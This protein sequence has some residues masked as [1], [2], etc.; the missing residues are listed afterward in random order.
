MSIANGKYDNI[1]IK[2]KKIAFFLI[3]LLSIGMI[4]FYSSKTLAT[5]FND[6]LVDAADLGDVAYVEKLLKQGYK[7]DQKGDFGTTALMR[8]AFRGNTELIKLL[9]DSGAYINSADIGGETALHLASKNGHADAVEML[10]SYGANVD[11]PDKE[12]WT[13]L[14]RATLAKQEEITKI[15][16]NKGANINAINDNKESVIMHAAIVGTPNIL[17]MILS[18]PQ[19][20]KISKETSNNAITLA[21]KKGNIEAEKILA[22]FSA[23]QPNNEQAPITEDTNNTST[24]SSNYGN[25]SS[26]LNT[27]P[28]K[29]NN[30]NTNQKS[31]NTN[32]T[33]T[34]SSEE[35]S[36]KIDTIENKQPK[37]ENVDKLL[38]LN[39]QQKPPEAITP[40]IE[41]KKI[42]VNDTTLTE[43][44]SIFFVQL[45]TFNNETEA[46]KSWDKVLSENKEPL[47]K[48]EPVIVKANVSNNA[49]DIV[50]RLRGGILQ[51]KKEA[52]EL[53]KTL[54]AKST[55]CF[56]VEIT[57]AGNLSPS[58]IKT[59]TKNEQKKSKEFAKNN[60]ATPEESKKEAKIKPVENKQKSEAMSASS[61]SS[62]YPKL[63]N[64]ETPPINTAIDNIKP[65]S[66][67]TTETPINQNVGQPLPKETL[68]AEQIPNQK[69]L[70][71]HNDTQ[72]SR[73]NWDLS[74]ITP[75]PQPNI[76][77]DV[78]TTQSYNTAVS[79]RPIDVIPPLEAAKPAIAS[80]PTTTQS[81][82][83]P[84]NNNKEDD[85]PFVNQQI[86]PPS[87]AMSNY[88][89]ETYKQER[90]KISNEVQELTKENFILKQGG[91]LPVKREQKEYDDF[92]K[93]LSKKENPVS[94]AVLVPDETYFAGGGGD[95]G[96][97]INITNLPNETF[98]ND[99]GLRMFKYD[100]SL[101]NVQIMVIKPVTTTANAPVGMRVGPMIASKAQELCE[102]VK[103][104]SY[105]C[106]I[107]GN[108]ESNAN[109]TTKQTTYSNQQ[110][111]RMAN[112][113]DSS[114]NPFS[115]QSVEKSQ[116]LGF[117][118]NLGTFPNASEAEYYWMFIREDNSDI[119]SSL[120]YDLARPKDSDMGGNN[121]IQLRTGPFTIK[122]RAA[123]I[124][125]IMRYRNIACLV[126][127]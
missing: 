82:P 90:E 122:Q 119:L 55:E 38:T 123:Q 28:P 22:N 49:E 94:E 105:G 27:T 69:T 67:E 58:P 107:S 34:K 5:S 83:A 11:I 65:Q 98:A 57:N 101:G 81:I 75:A 25:I 19:S 54:R 10:I 3:F 62:S 4:L 80:V 76:N 127:E 53:C 118:I 99:Y 109:V 102:T 68:Q 111:K 95:S 84:E 87:Q 93:D 17:S 29:E 63:G 97:W 91:K 6:P 96:S 104:G 43:S 1:L 116:N 106:T 88:K 126:T 32:I 78:T 48:L 120:Q 23:K 113:Q 112:N 14:M 71:W 46:E 30:K 108:G 18:N 110:T 26:L 12:N 117:W 8:A 44:G 21:K 41:K 47:D 40:P 64:A 7:I 72:S 121:A 86:P 114:D 13:P 35:P 24:T 79:E 42:P 100:E 2:N 59:T 85:N 45:G 103:S 16:L 37:P 50:Y 20:S 61:F 125:N 39:E 52:D 74:E 66:L 115:Q 77:K 31:G 51:N 36:V 15:L 60:Q 92:Y 70:P 89:A 73:K 56:V 33:S 124:C 9:A